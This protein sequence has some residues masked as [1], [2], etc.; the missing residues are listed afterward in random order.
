M[1][2]QLLLTFIITFIFIKVL[3][4]NAFNVGLVD[5][6]NERSSHNKNI[7]RGA[8]IGFILSIYIVTILFDISSF[9]ENWYIYFSIFVVFIVGI[10]DDHRDTS[11]KTKFYIIIFA[12]IVLYLNGISIDS[13]GSFLGYKIS[14][15]Y[16]SLPFTIFAVAGLTNALNLIDGLDG[17][18]ASVSIVI[19]S[20]FVY[21]GYVFDDQ[22]IFKLA[23][24]FIVSLFSF[25]VFNWNPAK[26]FMGDSGSL[27]IGFIISVL[28]ILS[29]KY[30]EPVTLLFITA[31]PVIDTLVVMI[32]R[33]KKGKS[34]F[35]PDKTHI[36][37][38]LY[39]FFSKNV[40]LT[41]IVI[42]LMQSLFCLFGYLA[43]RHIEVYPDGLF[44]FS[45]LI[46]F[47]IIILLS[48]LIFT[49]MNRRQRLVEKLLKRVKH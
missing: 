38:I 15:S 37:H 19:L 18:A 46:G 42:S 21:I 45:L 22:V 24:L 48:Y 3:I 17:L 36:H 26:I 25:L 35:S 4:K 34:P 47:I 10:L 31:I 5:I 9:L 28:S 16:L 6:P 12:T 32:R 13:L 11:P 23:L 43:A 39:T 8:G 27:T 30:I 49:A 41:V 29:L 20:T 14:L 33:I 1:L 40:R 2:F 7:A 44:P